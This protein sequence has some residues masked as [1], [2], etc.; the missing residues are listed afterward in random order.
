MIN[1]E[2]GPSA[3]GTHN[4]N[5]AATKQ[6]CE[7]PMLEVA[8]VVHTPPGSTS[9]TWSASRKHSDTAMG[10]RSAAGGLME[11]DKLEEIETKVKIEVCLDLWVQL[12]VSLR[13]Q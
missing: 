4:T 1:S 5:T 7:G 10:C 11:N 9:H 2:P 8:L 3:A 12:C 6:L 13:K